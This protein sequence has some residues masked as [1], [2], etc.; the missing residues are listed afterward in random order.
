MEFVIL[1]LYF[2]L[3]YAAHNEEAYYKKIGYIYLF[4]EDSTELFTHESLY[5]VFFEFNIEQNINYYYETI[6]KDFYKDS[7]SNRCNFQSHKIFH[8][9]LNNIT[10]N[11]S[12][13][14]HFTDQNL[15]FDL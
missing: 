5:D 15:P 9:F 10:K 6:T 14:F 11:I 13:Y 12:F 8:S 3:T 4:G 7:Y 1:S 2:T